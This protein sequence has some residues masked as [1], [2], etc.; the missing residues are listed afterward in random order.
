V[1]SATIPTFGGASDTRF[2]VLRRIG[3]QPANTP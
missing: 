1:H 2:I 3:G